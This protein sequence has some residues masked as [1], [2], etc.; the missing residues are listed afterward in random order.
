MQAAFSAP[1]GVVP[2][3]T[4][5]FEVEPM[6]VCGKTIGAL[7]VRPYDYEAGWGSEG[8]AVLQCSIGQ[9]LGMRV[10]AMICEFPKISSN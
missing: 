3:M 2:S 9:T 5:L 10:N 1:K 4:T 6:D 8:R 7:A